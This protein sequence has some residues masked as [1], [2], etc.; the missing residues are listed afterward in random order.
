MQEIWKD[1]KGYEGFYQ[2]SNLGNVKSL[3][4]FVLKKNL[5][6]RQPWNQLLLLCHAFRYS[7]IMSRFFLEIPYETRTTCP[8]SRSLYKRKTATKRRCL[9]FLVIGTPAYQLEWISFC[10]CRTIKQNII[11]EFHHHMQ[12]AGRFDLFA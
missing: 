12:V 6:A 3:D 9:S 7:F 4:V 1:V 8:A 11:R 10:V 5:N 2:V